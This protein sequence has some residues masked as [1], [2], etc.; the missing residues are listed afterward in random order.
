[1]TGSL[2]FR[3]R[4]AA[5][6]AAPIATPFVSDGPLEMVASAPAYLASSSAT[7]AAWAASVPNPGNVT[8]VAIAPTSA[9]SAVVA[10]AHRPTSRLARARGTHTA[11]TEVRSH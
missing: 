10:S 4:M 6:A 5:A 2:L 7:A 1:M 9:S 3:A 8:P 11:D